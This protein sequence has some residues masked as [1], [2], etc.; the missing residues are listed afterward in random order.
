MSNFTNSISYPFRF[1]LFL[2]IVFLF[3]YFSGFTFAILGIFPR[4]REGLVGIA[5]APL[6]HGSYIHLLSNSI[7]LI[8][9]GTV[10]YMFYNQI[11]GR[12]FF[13]GYFLTGVFVWCFARP[14][15]HIGASGLVYTIA[16]FL[17]FIG[18]FRR[19]IPSLMISII[20]SFFY[21]GIIYGILPSE[22][23][24]SF[25]SHLFGALIGACAAFAFRNSKKILKR[26]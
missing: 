22:P 8:I 15:Y 7:P 23:N 6:I 5:L 17:F 16:F 2:W 13:L 3:E 4:D 12:V 11:A 21:G 10:L 20:T 19:D 1:V 14:S 24:V 9:L 26:V 18:L 25:E